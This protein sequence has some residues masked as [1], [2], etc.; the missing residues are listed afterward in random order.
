MSA[1]ICA[2]R[3][4]ALREPERGKTLF[5]IQITPRMACGI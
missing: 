3:L 4:R 1:I 2:L 5:L